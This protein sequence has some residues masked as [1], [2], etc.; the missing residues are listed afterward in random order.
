[1]R[2]PLDILLDELREST[3]MPSRA[4]LYRLSCLEADEAAR[5]REVWPRLPVELRR[6]TMMRLVEVAEADFEVDFG[7]IFRLGLEDQDAK[8]RTAAVEGL[9]EDEDVRLVPLL[10]A[11]LRED[12]DATVRAAAATS[13]G[14][15]T[16]LGELGKIRP[17]PHT[18]AYKT[19]LAACQDAEECQ[20]VR[21]RALESLAYTEGEIV[22]ELIREAYAASEEKVRISAVFA[23]GRSA[24]NRWSPQVQQ[25]LFSPNPGLRYE[26]ARACGEL[27]LSEAVPE[28]GELAEDVD[29][30]VQEAAMWALGQIGGDRAQEILEYR[31]LAEDE[32]AR[33]AAEAALEE[34]EFL[35]RDLSFDRLTEGPDR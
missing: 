16:L 30:E 29:R 7:A 5:V 15:F 33:A 26:A 31:C 14:R 6:E 18:L 22:A 1:M 20:E 35:H 8:V 9:W 3:E 21:R 27:Q 17:D 2:H 12:E 19:L 23:M 34:L 4:L 11:R 24:D 13:L 28:L 25:E 32:V 10:A